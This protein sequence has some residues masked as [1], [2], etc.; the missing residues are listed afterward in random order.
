M[1]TIT[2]KLQIKHSLNTDIS[3]N[4]QST[5]DNT[6]IKAG[7]NVQRP[8]SFSV[9]SD[10]SASNACNLNLLSCCPSLHNNAQ[11]PLADCKPSD[12]QSQSD[13]RLSNSQ[14]VQMLNSPPATIQIKKCNNCQSQLDKCLCMLRCTACFNTECTCLM[15]CNACKKNI[16]KY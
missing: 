15:Q 13:I 8:Q 7:T 12:T 9:G 5:N 1:I 3:Q 4:I 16:S 14:S 10:I 2:L 11:F 6:D